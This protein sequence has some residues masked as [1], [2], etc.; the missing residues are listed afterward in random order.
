MSSIEKGLRKAAILV[1]S[2]DRAAAAA[3][4]RQLSVTQVDRLRAAIGGLGEIAPGER[5][6]VLEE[7]RSQS[8]KPRPAVDPPGIELSDRLARRFSLATGALGP[9]AATA[10]R[11]PFDALREAEADQLARALAAERPQT[12]AVVLSHLPP[13]QSGQVLVRL[14]SRVQVEV[15]RRLVELEATD[16]EV[17]RE[18]ERALEERLAQQVPLGSSR[19]AGLAAVSGILEAS[20]QQVAV[21]ILENLSHHDVQLAGRLGPARVQFDDLV[22]LDGA[23]LAQIFAAADPEEMVLALVGAPPPLV[24]RILARLPHQQADNLRHQLEHIGPTRLSDVEEARRRVA[25]TARKLAAAGAIVLPR[26][27]YR[28]E[29]SAAA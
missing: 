2:L 10:P 21:Q 29:V 18:V 7:F 20:G 25:E 3:L 16:P 15:V 13:Q 6:S 24:E 14:G 5:Q 9:R 1:S 22:D 4:L 11:Q 26:R 17:L 27:L 12:I 23:T 8:P 19:V 28:Q